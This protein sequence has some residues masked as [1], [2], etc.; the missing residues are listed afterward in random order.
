MEDFKNQIIPGDCVEVM[1]RLPDEQIDLVVTSPPHFIGI[2][3]SKKY[4]DI[5]RARVSE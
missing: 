1:A 3:I 4:C 5:A 2:E